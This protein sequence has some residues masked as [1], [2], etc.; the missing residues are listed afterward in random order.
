[1]TTTAT[2]L[3]QTAARYGLYG[4]LASWLGLTAAKQF[5][6]TPRFLTRIDPIN[7]AIPVTTFFAPNPGRS[8]IHVLG[9]ERLADGS[10]TQWCEYP[11]LERR[12][13]RHMLWHPGRRVEKLLPDTVSELTQL[14]LDEK[15]I[16]VLQ[17]TIPYLALLTFVTHHCP[18]PPGSRQVQFLVVSSGGFDEEEEPRTLFASDFHDLPPSRRT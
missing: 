14:A 3:P 7:T 10:T 18:H 6:K 4:V 17:L 15:R 16:E 8:D 13:I 9:R 11:M 12:T 1:M 5:R 2:A